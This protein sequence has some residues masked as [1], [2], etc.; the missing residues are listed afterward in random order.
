VARANAPMIDFDDYQNV[1]NHKSD[2]ALRT[3]NFVL[4]TVCHPRLM[5]VSRFLAKAGLFLH[6]PGTVS[7]L[8]K[9]VFRQFC[10]GISL[11]EA[12]TRSEKIHEYGVKTILD[13]AVEA[14]E[15]QQGFERV[16]EEYLRVIAKTASEDAVEMIA[17]K[18]SAFVRFELLEKVSGGVALE[19]L[20][21]EEF[22]LAKQRLDLLAHAASDARVSLFVDAEHSWVQGAIDELV[23]DLMTRYNHERAVVLGTL[24]LY[25]ANRIPVLIA[26]IAKARANNYRLGIK[27]VR[28]AYLERE[29][30]RAAE[31]QYASPIQACKADTDRDYDRATT[32]CLENI[33]IL[34]ACIA[35]HNVESTRHMVRE[36]ARLGI[37]PDDRRVCSSQLLGMFDRIT[38]PL[39]RH[40]YNVLKYVPYGG[41]RDALPYLMRRADENRCVAEQLRGELEAVRSEMRR[42]GLRPL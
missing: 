9:T 19:G 23:D 11:E 13:Y 38:V 27:L 22:E 34:T 29:A 37:S 36:M 2:Q 21:E 5:K 26:A 32:L 10:G 4:W 15:D 39:A 14:V 40:G 35:T 28:G 8:Q 42:R 18:V 30:E 41:V 31:F 7:A 33:D 25:L 17:L 20:E 1:F 24:Q 16:T 3:T 12:V 6:V